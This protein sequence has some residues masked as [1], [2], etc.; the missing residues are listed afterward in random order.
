MALDSTA[1]N[2]ILVVEDEPFI[3]K[4]LEKGVVGRVE[5][6]ADMP[7]AKLVMAEDG[8]QG[9][10]AVTRENARNILAM[11]CDNLMPGQ[12]GPAVIQ[13][14]IEQGVPPTRILMY[15]TNNEDPDIKAFAAEARVTLMGK[16][17]PDATELVRTW[18]RNTLRAS[19]TS[20]TENAGSDIST[21]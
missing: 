20:P 11:I 3:R 12:N 19:Q 9:I 6:E 21:Q 18:L 17:V 15:T 7:D 14:A 10:A 1:E 5:S 16:T 2:I 8:I 13:H 4:I